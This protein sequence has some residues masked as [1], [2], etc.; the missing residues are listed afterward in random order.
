MTSDPSL[1]R[2]SPVDVCLCVSLYLGQVR[3]MTVRLD[4]RLLSPVE[5][6]LIRKGPGN[7]YFDFAQQIVFTD[8]QHITPS[9]HHHHHHY[10]QQQQQLQQQQLQQL[11]QYM[12]AAAPSGCD[13]VPRP[14]GCIFFHIPVHCPLLS[15]DD[16]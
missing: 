14:R 12:P 15:H 7:C 1:R 2:R 6:F 11:Q 16:R 3:L 8:H 13:F 10:H 5:G 9:H 4:G